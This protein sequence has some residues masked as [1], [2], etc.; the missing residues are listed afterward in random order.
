MFLR[1]FRPLGSGVALEARI[2]VQNWSK[3]PGTRARKASK[4]SAQAVSSSSLSMSPWGPLGDPL[5]TDFV[6]KWGPYLGPKPVK[7]YVFMDP[8]RATKYY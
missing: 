8:Q 5:E 6:V 3:M 1:D 2:L 7:K 4:R